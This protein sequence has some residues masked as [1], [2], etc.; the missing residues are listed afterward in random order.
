MFNSTFI[1]NK[2]E[3]NRQEFQQAL[4]GLT[5]EEYLWKPLPEKWC[6]LEVVCHLHDEER[7][8]FR[9][10]LKHVLERPEN[11]MSPIDP[12]SWV[13]ERK[14][15]E[16][17]YDFML[18]QF[19]EERAESIRWLRALKD[20]RWDN[21]HIHPKFGTHSGKLF[22]SNWLAHDYLHF[23][24][25]LSLKYGFLNTQSDEDLNYAGKW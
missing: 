2:L 21:A 23:R 5:K 25:I 10:R 1:I 17:D 11:V 4:S 3:S 6:L 16:Q 22:L 12:V 8:D 20:T 9:A 7:E 14:Y 18:S 19:Q 13:T 15:M 24:Q